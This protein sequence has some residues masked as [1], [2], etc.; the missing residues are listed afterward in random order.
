MKPATWDSLE[1]SKAESEK[2][3][4]ACSSFTVSARLSDSAMSHLLPTGRAVN[5]T[6]PPIGFPK[7]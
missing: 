6:L 4:V 7:S 2:V 3:A 1:S 5:P